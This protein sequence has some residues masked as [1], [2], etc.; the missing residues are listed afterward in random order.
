MNDPPGPQYQ[1]LGTS[2]YQDLYEEAQ[3]FVQQEVDN[4]DYADASLGSTAI[5]LDYFSE[6]P[7]LSHDH[8]DYQAVH[9]SPYTVNSIDARR[10]RN[11]YP[12]FRPN[13]QFRKRQTDNRQEPQTVEYVDEV[14]DNL[15]L[16]EEG[17]VYDDNVF[18]QHSLLP[19]REQRGSTGR[20]IWPPKNESNPMGG[21]LAN[22]PR[23]SWPDPTQEE[24]A[25]TAMSSHRG[26]WPPSGSQAIS[27]SVP[28]QETSDAFSLSDNLDMATHHGSIHQS[29]A[30][31]QRQKGGGIWPGP[32]KATEILYS[33]RQTEYSSEEKDI[34]LEYVDVGTG[35]NHKPP[36]PPPPPPPP[37]RQQQQQ[38]QQIKRN[39][40]QQTQQS[41][42]SQ[43]QQQQ[44][45]H[46][47]TRRL[48][49]RQYDDMDHKVKPGCIDFSKPFAGTYN[50]FANPNQRNSEALSPPPEAHIQVPREVHTGKSSSVDQGSTLSSIDENGSNGNDDIND[51]NDDNNFL[52]EL[53]NSPAY[54]GENYHDN[55]PPYHQDLQHAEVP[56]QQ[57][58]RYFDVDVEIDYETGEPLHK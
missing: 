41:K 17:P 4:N 21:L 25:P 58:L 30:L 3:S 45:T 51:Y 16:Y 34:P 42:R 35:T 7:G 12:S 29:A 46:T 43:Q 37:Q 5:D 54:A 8:V 48:S 27:A 13:D 26:I 44:Q 18:P 2:R 6:A 40:H 15:Y 47:S 10:S 28:S 20:G 50:D 52:G 1:D 31:I 23:G 39:Q 36:P 9:P 33:E 57:K 24:A 22:H 49:A 19:A 38:Q 32:A 55:N 53:D 56:P 14:G 11:E